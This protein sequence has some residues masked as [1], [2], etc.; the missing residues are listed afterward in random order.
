MVGQMHSFLQSLIKLELQLCLPIFLFYL[1]DHFTVG[2]KPVK[3][4]KKLPFYFELN[5]CQ[6]RNNKQIFLKI[7][8]KLPLTVRNNFVAGSFPKSKIYYSTGTTKKTWFFIYIKIL[9][10]EICFDMFHLIYWLH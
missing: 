9:I 6:I 2:Q 7:S 10:K 1:F 5:G 4:V 8:R 3:V